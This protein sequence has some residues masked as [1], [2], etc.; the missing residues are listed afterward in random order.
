MKILYCDCAHYDI[1]EKK[2]KEAVYSA[3]AA[4][5][6]ELVAV[7]DLCKVAAKERALLKNI[8]AAGEL[9]VI[10]CF[11]RAVTALFEY[12]GVSRKVKLHVFNMRTA[13]AA[14]IL[15]KLQIR[16]SGKPAEDSSK[17]DK[18][19]KNSWI[20]WYPVIEYERCVNCKQC[21]S[22]CLFG[23][24]ELSKN[25]K[26]FVAK[27]ENCKTNC[28]ACAKVCPKSAIIFPKYEESPINGGEVGKDAGASKNVK[29][30]YNKILGD[31]AY[32]ILH[33]R[34]LAAMAKLAG[35]K[36]VPADKKSPK[37][38]LLKKSK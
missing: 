16:A 28:P 14:E 21:L 30:D 18:A 10:A 26:V 13:S 15:G 25:G 38:R 3:L 35:D 6:M 27:P 9:A 7:P 19:D 20:P 11:P 1:V 12:A 23:V 4:S 24:Y 29:I 34:R 33:Q 17:K 2:K 37:M 5:G 22:F 31:D 8:A 36:T 32:A